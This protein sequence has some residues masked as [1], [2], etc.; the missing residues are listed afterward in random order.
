MQS[1]NVFIIGFDASLC[2]AIY[3]K[4]HSQARLLNKDTPLYDFYPKGSLQQLEHYGQYQC[5]GFCMKAQHKY[6]QET[7]EVNVYN[8]PPNLLARFS[9]GNETLKST[10]LF[11]F[12][13]NYIHTGFAPFE[14]VTTPAE[15]VQNW[16]LNQLLDNSRQYACYNIMYVNEEH[17]T[18]HIRQ[19]IRFCVARDNYIDGKKL[20][21]YFNTNREEP[22]MYDSFLRLRSLLVSDDFLS[23]KLITC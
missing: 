22:V 1:K 10:L 14:Y 16:Q 11:C 17:A 5:P 4:L 7:I 19:L 6:S 15:G 9:I 23:L 8:V 20:T 2:M 18:G 21:Y 12:D 3:N 13:Y